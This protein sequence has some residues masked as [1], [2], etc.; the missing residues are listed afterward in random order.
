MPDP[1]YKQKAQAAGVN[2][3]NDTLVMRKNLKDMKS[4]VNNLTGNN[5]PE[6]DFNAY[7]IKNFMFAKKNKQ[8]ESL[9][10]TTYGVSI[11]KENIK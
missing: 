10:M 3:Q 7:P 8:G 5:N 4:A 6:Y 11:P 9:L 2:I 1:L